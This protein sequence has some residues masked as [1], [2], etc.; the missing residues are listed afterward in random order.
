MLGDIS[1]LDLRLRRQSSIAYAVGVTAYALLIVVLYPTFRVDTSLNK[2]TEGDSSLSALFG[3]TGSLT[4]PDGWMNANLYANFLPLFVLFMTIGYGAS[5]VA[6]QNEDG[7]LGDVAVLPRTR[8]AVLLEKV[9]TLSLLS[10]PVPLLCLVASLAGHH[11]QVDLAVGAL[12]GTTIGVALLGVNLGL[13]AL[14]WGSWTGRRGG[15]LGVATGLAAVSYIVSSLAPVVSWIH[16]L[17]F[18][19]LF[20]WAVG[21][22]Q[23]VNG[24]SAPGVAVLL[25]SAVALGAV[26]WRGFQ[27]LDIR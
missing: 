3:A 19:S 10:L 2:L 21:D 17:R 8:A 4:S 6:G 11:W 18:Y 25:S 20:Y 9:A 27:Q 5:A 7:T 16:P 15:A 22:D 1:R 26:A 12:I 23:L 13:V 14:A 24:L